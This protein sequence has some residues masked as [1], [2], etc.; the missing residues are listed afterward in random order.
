MRYFGTLFLKGKEIEEAQKYAHKFVYTDLV[1]EIKDSTVKMMNEYKSKG[2]KIVLMSGSYLFVIEEV[3]KYFNIDYF[4]ASKLN[5]V[6]KL[7][8]GKYEIDILLNKYDILQK[9]FKKFDKLVVVSNNKTD[10]ELMKF[11]DQSF[12]ICNKEKDLKFWKPHFNILCIKD[13]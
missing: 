10:L 12:A 11:A 8:T 1:K 4:Y 5:I 13:Y 9:E 6:D 2:Y 7:Y 3:A